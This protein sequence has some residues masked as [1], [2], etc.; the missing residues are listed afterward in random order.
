MARDMQ[1]NYTV[2]VERI[3]RAFRSPA[4]LQK[5][6]STLFP[7]QASRVGYCVVWYGMV[8]YDMMFCMIRYGM[9]L[10]GTV[11]YGFV[12]YGIVWY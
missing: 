9:V 10:Y 1:T 12:W 2:R 11:W 5:F 3:P 7:G 6:F 4:I 8:W